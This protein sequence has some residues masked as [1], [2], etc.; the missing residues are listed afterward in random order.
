MQ[1]EGGTAE[2]PIYQNTRGLCV[3]MS[4]DTDYGDGD[5]EEPSDAFWEA[6]D[7][8]RDPDWHGEISLED[9]TWYE[10]EALGA[11]NRSVDNPDDYSG[12]MLELMNHAKRQCRD[13]DLLDLE[14]DR[15]RPEIETQT[16][17]KGDYDED[18]TNE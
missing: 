7:K 10:R 17:F 18:T 14:D 12:E 4:S 9:C 5:T 11:M 8:I 16:A 15:E 1:S 13:G 2:Y 3:W 6:L